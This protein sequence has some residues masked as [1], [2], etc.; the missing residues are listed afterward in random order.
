MRSE[1]ICLRYSSLRHAEIA[2]CRA[3]T[4]AVQQARPKPA[5]AAVVGVDVQRAGAEL[6]DALQHPDGVAQRAGAGE[7]PIEPDAA[8]ARLA[9]E[10]D[11]REVLADADLQIGKCLVVLQPDVEARLNVLDEPCFHQQRI[12]LAVGGQEINIGD[13]LARGRR[14]AYPR[15]RPW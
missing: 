3:L 6:K 15:R 10:L 5:P 14:C 1:R 7:R 4:D 9:R 13:E 11:A 8:A 12:D 2:R